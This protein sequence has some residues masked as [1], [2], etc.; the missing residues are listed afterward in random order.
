MSALSKI[1][2]AYLTA[3]MIALSVAVG[4]AIGTI[5]TS[6]M[7]KDSIAKLEQSTR[8]AILERGL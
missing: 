3:F 4:F 6:S 5:S 1:W 2:P 7:A 8:A